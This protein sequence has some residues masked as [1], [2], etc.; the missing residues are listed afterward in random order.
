MGALLAFGVI[1]LAADRRARSALRRDD[2]KATVDGLA[3]AARLRPRSLDVLLIAAARA[4]SDRAALRAAHDLIGASQDPDVVLA[5][6]DV[7]VG[8]ARAGEPTRLVQ[9]TRRYEAVLRRQPH[10][11]LAWLGHGEALAFAGDQSGARAS[12]V[13][14][15]DLLPRSPYPALDLGLL[16]LAA[17]DPVGACRWAA[18]AGRVP[19]GDR[20]ADDLRARIRGRANR[21]CP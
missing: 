18:A 7:L 15:H 9:A 11:G 20:L 1:G 2:P 10:N 17:G 16:D 21:S 6:A 14:A 12:F 13:K 19:A 8:L 5:D 3:S 4:G